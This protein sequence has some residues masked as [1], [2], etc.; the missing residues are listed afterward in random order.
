MRYISLHHHS[1][2]S[3]GDGYGTPEQHVER[4][5][6]LGYSAMALTEHGNTS[7]HVQLEKAGR[8]FNIKPIF[9][10]EAYTAPANMRETR[11]QRKWH[12]TLL[13]ATPEGYHNLNRMVSRS[14]AEGFYRWPTITGD[15]LA[16]HAD[17]I[18]CLSGCADSYLAC[19]LLGGK[20]IEPPSRPNVSGAIKVIH[21]FKDL[22][23][24]RYYLEVQQF[25]ELDRTKAINAIYAELS[26]KCRVPLVATS[27]VHYPNPDDNEMQ[28]ILHAAS[29][30]TGTVAAAEAE[31]EY[32]I[33]LTFPQSDQQI[34]ERLEATG[35]HKNEAY[36]AISSTRDIAARCNLELPKAKPIKYPGTTMDLLPWAN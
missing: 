28:K 17:G 19:T 12:L 9:G 14:W 4:A 6:E 35:L 33:R 20:G 21:K 27:D 29:R 16:D 8:K 7:S 30:N 24:D 31:W 3:F 36:C 26:N 32:S 10:L 25:P 1:T 23:G 22:L 18:I 15:I 2:F 5:A 11:N 13:A 34:L